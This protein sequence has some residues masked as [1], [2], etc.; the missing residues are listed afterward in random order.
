MTLYRRS[1]IE[2]SIAH[3]PSFEMI[4]VPSES[5]LVLLKAV[6]AGKL[7]ERDL[8]MEMR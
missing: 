3:P 6:E 2:S 1:R 4:V 8:K 5:A 7:A